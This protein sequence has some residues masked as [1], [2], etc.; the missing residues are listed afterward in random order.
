MKVTVSL[1]IDVDPAS[2]YEVYGGAKTP[3]EVRQDV[4]NYI[5]DAVSQLPGIEE[6]G[7]TVT[8]K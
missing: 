7:A 5:Y 3:A 2:W 1:V 8:I 4:R 6:S